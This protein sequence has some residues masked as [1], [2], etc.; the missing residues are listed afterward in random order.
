MSQD[1]KMGRDS[2]RLSLHDP[3]PKPHSK[4][5]CNQKP[6]EPESTPNT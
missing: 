4:R 1:G 2:L 6:G 5:L 3:L